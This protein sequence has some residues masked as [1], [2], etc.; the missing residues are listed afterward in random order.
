MATLYRNGGVVCPGRSGATAL[1]VADGEIGW[2]G[3]ED[4]AAEHVG[5]RTVDLAGALVTPAFVDAHLHATS[6][7]L[8]L[9]GIDLCRV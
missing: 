2:I 8:A 4:G 9:T 3:D 5:V 6:S 1:L 7:G